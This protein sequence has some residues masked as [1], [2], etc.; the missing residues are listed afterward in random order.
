AR[1]L[2]QVA[3]V[4]LQRVI[5]ILGGGAVG[6]PALAQ[7][8]DGRVEVL[9]AD[10]ALGEDLSRFRIL[11]QRPREKQPLDGDEAGPGLRGGSFGRIEKAGRGRRQVDLSRAAAG[12]FRQ[13]RK[14]VLG[15]LENRARITARAVD[16]TTGEPFRI[17]EQNFEDVERRKLLVTL[18]GRKRL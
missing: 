3:R 14:R 18:A 5:G 1:R 13:L 2:R 10:A 4:F 16:Q 8:V 12:N 7:G 15:L 9:R 17:V 11:V 6:G